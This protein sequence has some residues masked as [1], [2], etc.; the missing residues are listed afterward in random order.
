MAFSHVSKPRVITVDKNP[1][2]PIAIQELKKSRCL[3]AS[4]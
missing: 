1:A 2:Y 4:N 3:K